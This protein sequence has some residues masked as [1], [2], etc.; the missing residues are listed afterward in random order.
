M[1]AHLRYSASRVSFWLNTTKCFILEHCTLLIF[2]FS[3]CIFSMSLFSFPG[4]RG[5]SLPSRPPHLWPAIQPPTHSRLHFLH[6]AHPGE[7]R[8][9]PTVCTPS[10]ACRCTGVGG[11]CCPVD[12]TATRDQRWPPL[13]IA[14]GRSGGL[15]GNALTFILVEY[16]EHSDPRL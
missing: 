8:V 13:V 14:A 6:P 3:F 16:S 15:G 4:V 9:W 11:S 12:G 1:S 10:R 2:M 5:L 7:R